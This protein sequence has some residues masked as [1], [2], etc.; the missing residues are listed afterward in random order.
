MEGIGGLAAPD[1]MA[2]ACSAAPLWQ[3]AQAPST[4]ACALFLNVL[5]KTASWQVRHV[6]VSTASAFLSVGAVVWAAARGGAESRPAAQITPA[7]KAGKTRLD[8]IW[9]P[10]RLAPSLRRYPV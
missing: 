3:L 6:P 2:F 8:C 4:P 1:C 10:P 9:R 5:L 7:T